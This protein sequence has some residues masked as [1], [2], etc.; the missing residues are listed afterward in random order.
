M[1][2][3]QTILQPHLVYLPLVVIGLFCWLLP[4]RIIGISHKSELSLVALIVV[5]AWYFLI[6][7]ACLLARRVTASLVWVDRGRKAY[8]PLFYY[9]LSAMAVL[10]TLGTLGTLGSLGEVLQAIREQQVNDLKE[11]LYSDYSAGLLTLRYAAVLAGVYALYRLLV[12]R[13]L[14]LLDMGNLLLMLVCAFISARIMLI[15]TMF[16]FLFVFVNQPSAVRRPLRLSRVKGTMLAGAAFAAIVVFTYLR[17]A[18]TYKYELGV[19]NPIAVTA[20]ELGRYAGMP[21]QVTIG[22]GEII[23]TTEVVERTPIRPLYLAPTFLHSDDIESDN[24]GGVGKQ[25]YLGLIDLPPTLTTNSALAALVGYLGFWA[26]LAMPLVCFF[27][28]LL[29][30]AF[31]SLNTFEA[32]L[33]QAVT[34]YAFFEIW[35]LYFFS[36]GSFIFLNLLMLGFF[37]AQ[38]LSGRLAIGRRPPRRRAA[39]IRTVSPHPERR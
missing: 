11:L 36:A 23:A 34:L 26:F 5:V 2:R 28:A 19:T 24:S 33:Y 14:S 39:P 35:R 13:K 20:V 9:V 21:I 4:P 38:V 25:W 1:R 16:C 7:V 10:G 12:L 27:H 29:F 17:S 22:V 31:R 37:V 3:L 8:S 18:N 32:R 30:F 15:Q 6:V